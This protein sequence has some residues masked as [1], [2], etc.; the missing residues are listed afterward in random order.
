M[1]RK[2]ELFIDAVSGVLFGTLFFVFTIGFLVSLFSGN[3]GAATAFGVGHIG[4]QML[5]D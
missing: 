2:F 4:M 1:W 5:V 3:W